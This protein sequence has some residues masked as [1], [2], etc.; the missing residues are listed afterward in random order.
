MF[1]IITES[2]EKKQV[3][4]MIRPSTSP[5]IRRQPLQD[6]TAIQSSSL[7]ASLSDSQMRGF[8][9]S[10]S[11]GRGNRDLKNE[12]AEL[13]SLKDLYNDT[14]WK[15]PEQL[16]AR[17]GDEL[18]YIFNIRKTFVETYQG[19][20]KAYRKRIEENKTYVEEVQNK[21]QD[22]AKERSEI[23]RKKNELVMGIVK[24]RKDMEELNVKK[25]ELIKS[26]E[27]LGLD[28][29][30]LE[31]DLNIRLPQM[32]MKLKLMMTL[33]GIYF[34]VDQCGKDERK[35][36]SDADQVVKGFVAKDGNSESLPFEYNRKETLEVD[37]ADD[38]WS[39]I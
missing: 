26:F 5:F 15:N 34:F 23:E 16:F 27:K 29:K 39:K 13:E 1:D 10:G 22:I 3:E 28:D 11:R 8:L 7:N 2:F 33:F 36:D 30:K 37:I 6:T 18:E 32:Q 4:T 24:E 35:D 17:I 38:I 20:V 19:L 21:G 12:V 9:A 14:A 31:N 25:E